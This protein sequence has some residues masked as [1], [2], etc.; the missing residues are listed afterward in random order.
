[1]ITYALS[2]EFMG[3]ITQPNIWTIIKMISHGLVS[4]SRI[5]LVRLWISFM[6]YI[7]KIIDPEDA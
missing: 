4:F 7:L 1:M 3:F 5:P 6:Q 2:I